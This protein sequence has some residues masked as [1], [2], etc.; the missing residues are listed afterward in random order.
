MSRLFASSGQSIGA[1]ASAS[2]LPMNIQDW[3]PL[4]WTG[5]ISLQSKGLSRVF[6]SITVWKHQ[7]FGTQPSLW[8]NIHHLY[9]T[10]GKTITLTLWTFVGTWGLLIFPHQWN[11]VFPKPIGW[12]CTSWLM[13]VTAVL[14][15]DTGQEEGLAELAISLWSYTSLDLPSHPKMNC[16]HHTKA[17]EVVKFSLDPC[18]Q[19]PSSSWLTSLSCST[20]QPPASLWSFWKSPW[21]L[22]FKCHPSSSL[23]TAS[24]DGL[25]GAALSSMIP[26]SQLPQPG[27]CHHLWFSGT[28][29]LS[30]E[31]QHSSL[32]LCA[33][34]IPGSIPPLMSTSTRTSIESR[35]AWLLQVLAAVFLQTSVSTPVW[36]CQG[37]LNRIPQTE[38]LV[39]QQ[40]VPSVLEAGSP[41]SRCRQGWF[42]PRP[43]SLVLDP[44]L[45]FPLCL[46]VLLFF[47]ILTTFK[48]F[49]A[50]A[51]AAKSLQSC[52]TLCDPIDGSPSGCPVPG[53]L[54]ARTLEWVAISFSNAWKWKVKVKSLSR[55]WLPATPGTAAHQAPPS[56]GFSKQE[57][58]SGVPL[59]VTILLLLLISG[60]LAERY[61][62][63]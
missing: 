25:P 61:V 36:I 12:L 3:F 17:Q 32:I 7:F 42:L 40:C 55:I 15:G 11:L 54:Q 27:V 49:I 43:F 33:G 44:H 48:D 53:I 9:M 5:L 46:S 41:R 38:W 6:S 23:W 4:G 62:G 22:F 60:F 10:T 26:P 56:M 57:Y 2:V 47:L 45:V 29:V 8:S 19:P 50:A 16:K 63:C 34:K 21:W 39:Q 30:G 59:P 14:P 52:P 28:S 1:S 58:W 37:H 20:Q 13:E 51:A 18:L 31:W 24:S 35:A